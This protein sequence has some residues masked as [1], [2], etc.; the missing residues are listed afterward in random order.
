MWTSGTM[1]QRLFVDILIPFFLNKGHIPD[2][3]TQTKNSLHISR[4]EWLTNWINSIYM[5][6]ES[7]G[8]WRIHSECDNVN[9]PSQ[10]SRRW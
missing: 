5:M 1:I 6:E 9:R 8:N 4:G 2:F 7:K 3:C 10:C